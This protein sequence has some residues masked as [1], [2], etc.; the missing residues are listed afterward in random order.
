MIAQEGK[1]FRDGDDGDFNF[2]LGGCVGVGVGDGD[3]LAATFGR[4]LLGF[5]SVEFKPFSSGASS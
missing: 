1:R 3:P 2:E 5:L 4:V